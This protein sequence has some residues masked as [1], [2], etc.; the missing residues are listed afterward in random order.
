[1]ASPTDLIRMIM[2]DKKKRYARELQELRGC[3]Y[4]TALNELRELSQETSWRAYI[5][6]VREQLASNSGTTRE[7]K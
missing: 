4:Q 7:P 1:M 5:D 6:R 2:A 3:T